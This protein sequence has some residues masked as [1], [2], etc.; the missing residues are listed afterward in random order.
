MNIF[1]RLFILLLGYFKKYI[2]WYILIVISL[3]HLFATDNNKLKN[4]VDWI[5]SNRVY[6]KKGLSVE[7]HKFIGLF[8]LLFSLYSGFMIFIKNINNQATDLYFDNLLPIV[9]LWLAIGNIIKFL[10]Y[11]RDSNDTAIVF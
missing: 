5:L 3:F 4:S 8:L 6:D 10:L 2:G 9:L 7:I 11:R 1:F